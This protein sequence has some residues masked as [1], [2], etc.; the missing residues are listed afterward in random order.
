MSCGEGNAG[1]SCDVA[2]SPTSVAVLLAAYFIEEVV[3]REKLF[4]C[5]SISI[6][7]NVIKRSKGKREG[8][9]QA[10]GSNFFA[11]FSPPLNK[12]IVVL[13]VV[14]HLFIIA[15]TIHLLCKQ[16]IFNK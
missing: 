11:L 9:K 12:I 13:F 7:I 5:L 14:Q 1:S 4:N 8:Y 2:L 6:S 10:L 3:N 15:I 16:V